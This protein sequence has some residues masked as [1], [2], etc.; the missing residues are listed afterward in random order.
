M[1]RGTRL[2][3]IVTAVGWL[4]LLFLGALFYVHWSDS[5]SRFKELR[6]RQIDTHQTAHQALIELDQRIASLS[7]EQH[8]T[9]EVVDQ[10]L[11]ELRVRYTAY[12]T[13]LQEKLAPI[14]IAPDPRQYSVE[15]VAFLLQI[16]QYKQDYLQDYLGTLS[17]IRQ[18]RR[19]LDS[20]DDVRYRNLIQQMDVAL[21]T[22]EGYSGQEADRA[23]RILTASWLV[24]SDTIRE[25]QSDVAQQNQLTPLRT[26]GEFWDDLLTNFGEHLNVQRGAPEA[27]KTISA[28]QHA[29]ILYAVQTEM[30]LAR[31]ALQSHRADNYAQSIEHALT[32]LD[33]PAL[34]DAYPALKQDLESLRG[35]QPF[36]PDID[37]A[38]LQ[39]TLAQTQ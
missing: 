12:E 14:A 25:L 33:K 22:L 34:N 10:F 24:L 11:E 38:H 35:Q 18:A 3:F 37:F 5:H 31:L 26:W 1:S 27:V 9:Q 6:D 21:A 39:H 16:A 7:S 19:T 13:L 17:A 32:L 20:L 30:Y 15:A 29:L 2:L 36:P 28:Y 8:Q 23:H 4:G